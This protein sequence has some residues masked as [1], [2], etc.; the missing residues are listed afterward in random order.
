MM[1]RH[2]KYVLGLKTES[3]CVS[4]MTRHVSLTL[5]YDLAFFLANTYSTFGNHD[6]EYLF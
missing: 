4:D 6:D 2:Q 3:T 1:D 5:T